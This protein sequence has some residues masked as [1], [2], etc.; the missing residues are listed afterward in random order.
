MVNSNLKR[1]PLVGVRISMANNLVITVC[2]LETNADYEAYLPTI[3]DTLT[4]IGT[5]KATISEPWTK[6][7][8][9]GVPTSM[10]LEE[11]RDDVEN[12][13][14]RIKHLGGFLQKQLKKINVHL[15]LFLQ[16]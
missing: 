16:C 13:Y 15:L 11:I 10:D 1:C 3:V 2:L 6:Y 9:H 4:F 5:G 12:W 8:L 7:L 14:T